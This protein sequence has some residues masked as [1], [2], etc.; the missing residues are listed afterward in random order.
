MTGLLEI[1]LPDDV[2]ENLPSNEADMVAFLS[3]YFDGVIDEY[4]A[5][6]VR[7]VRGV[8]GGPLSR[9][10]RATIK[11][12]LIRRVGGSRLKKKFDQARETGEF[13]KMAISK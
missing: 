11:D 7:E 12:F 6:I 9:Y 8:M 5:D 13:D 4:Q 1:K 2:M 3:K 10:E